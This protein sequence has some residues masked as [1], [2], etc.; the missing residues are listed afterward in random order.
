MDVELAIN[1]ARGWGKGTIHSFVYSRKVALP[2]K[3]GEA[4]LRID[5][6]FQA[7]VGIDYDN[8]AKVVVAR[9]NGHAK[10]GLSGVEQIEE[11]FLFLGKGGKMLMRVY[12]VKGHS[13]KSYILNGERKEA[14]ELL[15][16]GFA[17]S[18]LGIREKA[19]DDSL[20]G[21][22]LY[23]NLENVLEMK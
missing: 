7:R 2:K 8:I 10:G 13:R 9:E 3:W 11:D 6:S 20:G 4:D 21:V 19:S 12:P 17:K 1:K 18:L 14:S 5:S 22:A 15:A 23:L 16:M